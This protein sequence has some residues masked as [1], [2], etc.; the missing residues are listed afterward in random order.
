MALRWWK[1]SEV[2]YTEISFCYDAKDSHANHMCV[3]LPNVIPPGSKWL[4]DCWLT[5]NS[6]LLRLNL[7]A[8]LISNM[9]FCL[10]HEAALNSNNSRELHSVWDWGCTA[11]RHE[12]VKI[13]D[14]EKSQV[15]SLLQPKKPSSKI[16]S[17][18]CDRTDEAQHSWVLQTYWTFLHSLF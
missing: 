14:L 6:N 2:R 12:C 16:S 10:K 13:W 4:S 5:Y 8:S 7:T 11:S 3:K 15:Q 9:R 17:S 1:K 18:Q